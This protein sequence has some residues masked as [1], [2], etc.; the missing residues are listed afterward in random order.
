MSVPDAI[1]RRMQAAGDG[2]LAEGTAIA[3]EI[4]LQARPLCQGAYLMP[5]FNKFEMA[6]DILDALPDRGPA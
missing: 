3:T 4:L 5:P 1:R 2:G 6:G